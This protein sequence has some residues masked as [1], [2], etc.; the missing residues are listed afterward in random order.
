[1][2]TQRE[3]ISKVRRRV[4][5]YGEDAKY[6]DEFY[7]DAIDFGL[8]KLSHDFDVTY[9]STEDVPS[10]R[11]FL[12]IKLATIEMCYIRVA[13]L[14][15]EDGDET[16]PG[17]ASFHSIKVPD[18]EVEGDA[19]SADEAAETWLKLANKLQIEYDAELEHVGGSSNAAEIQTGYLKRISLSSGGYRK[20]ALD[21]GPSAVTVSAVVTG[22]DVALSWSTWYDE[23][24]GAYEVWRDT[25]SA[26]ENEERIAY[27]ADNHD[28]TFTDEGRA[29]GTYY[30][31][32]KTVNLNLLKANSNLLTVTVT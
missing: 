21:E 26:M 23:T 28:V 4:A 17:D 30:Y 20:Y 31:R 8:G 11:L 9:T 13:G 19:A 2:A 7:A 10:H 22:G 27:F 12:L 32:V 6:E 16:D 18:L 25:D 24:F 3:I 29:A 5:D 14:V 1:M 15:D